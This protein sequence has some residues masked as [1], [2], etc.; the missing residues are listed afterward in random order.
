MAGLIRYIINGIY[1]W[2][3]SRL[4]IFVAA[5]LIIYTLINVYG[6]KKLCRVLNILVFLCI[7]VTIL[8]YTLSVRSVKGERTI[9]LIPFRR[10]FDYRPT[11]FKFMW[12]NAFF[13]FPFGL[14][15]PYILPDR[16]R[17]KVLIT[18]IA[19]ACVSVCIELAQYVFK[20]GSCETDDIIM[21]TFGAAVGTLSYAAAVKMRSKKTNQVSEPDSPS[22]SEQNGIQ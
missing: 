10:F 4:I 9:R 20:L 8:Y 1:R 12:L 17:R 18:V 13:F 3:Y 5:A 16:F 6:P 19:A 11:G 22:G 2:P 21:N 14:S 7:T 15:L